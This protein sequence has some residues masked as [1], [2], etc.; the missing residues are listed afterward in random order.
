M[1]HL[2]QYLE[3]SASNVKV[4]SGEV[5]DF[6]DGGGGV[7]FSSILIVIWGSTIVIEGDSDASISNSGS[8]D[9]GS[10][11]GSCLILKVHRM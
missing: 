10:S 6:G 8:F 3:P 4:L 2:S 7:W 1:S 9:F 11:S 5:I